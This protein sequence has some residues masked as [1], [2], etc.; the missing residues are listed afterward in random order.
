MIKI[1]DLLLSEC[2]KK[3]KQSLE[4]TQ[5]EFNTIRTGR[6]SAALLDRIFVDY[7]GAKTQLRFIANITIPESRTIIISP[8]E[9]KFIKEIEKQI[10][11]SDLSINPT[12]DGRVMRL[13][14]PSLNE[15]RRHE[16]VKLVRKISEDG[17]V[18][19][20]NIRR[21]INEELKK[22]ENNKEITKD[23]LEEYH[24]KTQELTDRYIE[25]INE[26]L[27]LKEK[28]IMEV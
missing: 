9:P 20:R 3:M 23:D 28:E 2:E 13:N 8:Y 7:Y 24:A 16:L 25:R 15:E 14:I 17:R 4:N 22:L 1:K 5:H 19:V 26:S 12:N 18:A 11:A 6:A 21:E 10:M 27:A